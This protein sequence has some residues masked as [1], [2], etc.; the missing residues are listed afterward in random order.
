MRRLSGVVTAL[1]LGMAGASSVAAQTAEPATLA[2][3]G[4]A[5][6]INEFLAARMAQDEHTPCPPDQVC[7]G[8]DPLADVVVTAAR[9][10]APGI[11]NNQQAGVDEGDVVKARGETLVILRRGRLF[12][13]STAGGR[14]Q[15]VDSINAYPPGVN[16]EDD[17]YD[18]MLVSGDRV[19]VI[20]YSYGRGGTEIN[21]FLMDAEGRLTFE[22][23]HHLTSDD[24]YSSR[25]YAS[26]L[27]GEQLIIYSPLRLWDAADLLE[28][29]PTLTAWR[30]GNDED[31][32]RAPGLRIV[33]PEDVH[34]APDLAADPDKAP[35]AIH[36]VIRCDLGA[37]ALGCEATA[38]LGPESR[39]FYVA[40][41]AV[42]VWMS[43]DPW[44]RREKDEAPEAWLHRIPID[45]AAPQAAAARGV[46]IDQFSF[47]EDAEASRIDV[48]VVSD[49]DGDGMWGSENARGDAA[50][51]TLPLS[52]FGDGTEP[53]DDADYRRLPSTG[54]DRGGR[55]NRFVG[56]HL[57]YSTI[58]SNGDSS[59]DEVTPKHEGVLTVVPL[60]GGQARRFMLAG[61]IGRIEAMGADA[62]VV[63]NDED[64]VFTT[65]GLGG[66]RPMLTDQFV[67]PGAEESETRSHAFFYQP[68]ALS[69]DGAAGILGLP[70]TRPDPSEGEGDGWRPPRGQASIAYL[71]R[72][73]GRLRSLGSLD[74]DIAPGF[75][76]DGCV[77]SCI[78]WYGDARPIFLGG[79]VFA[80][81]GYELVEGRERDGRIREVRRVNVTP[82]APEGPRPYYPY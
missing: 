28:R 24:Y 37:T 54:P 15:A 62:L 21:R 2:N 48:M 35:R 65:V 57:L 41:T 5:A 78:D 4:S 8:D 60:D 74:S 67:I 11:T 49:G 34:I 16:P 82:P 63:S 17:W 52:R 72:G 33:A 42:Y 45:G 66:P 10:A 77:A 47:R 59:W 9:N 38:I 7:D 22:D 20:G 29:L 36:T 26:R 46:P 18:E 39:S 81:L 27:I 75:I 12:T 61:E 56:D 30:P 51:L 6:G 80:L 32:D 58:V 1:C 68:D 25:N 53:P 55:R 19:I 13:V 31:D 69:P 70:V 50:L 76:D 14:L 40:P 23:S 64:V 3:F 71:R 73:G 43:E 79:R 44:D